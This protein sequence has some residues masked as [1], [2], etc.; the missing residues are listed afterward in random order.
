MILPVTHTRPFSLPKLKIQPS[1]DSK[2]FD[3]CMSQLQ[4]SC[5]FTTLQ[6]KANL[7]RLR[8]DISPHACLSPASCSCCMTCAMCGGS[9]TGKIS[10]SRL[11]RSWRGHWWSR[12][13]PR[14]VSQM[15]QQPSTAREGGPREGL[16]ARSTLPLFLHWLLCSIGKLLSHQCLHQ[17][18]FRPCLPPSSCCLH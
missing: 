4:S 11:L 9:G 14:M 13:E 3:P 2:Q 1:D 5:Q 15:A 7:D 6:K 18:P 8:L 12:R 17:S 16:V 10:W